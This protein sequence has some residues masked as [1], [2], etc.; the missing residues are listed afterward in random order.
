MK[1][2]AD[3]LLRYLVTD[4]VSGEDFMLLATNINCGD[5]VVLKFYKNKFVFE[6]TKVIHRKLRKTGYICKSIPFSLSIRSFLYRII[7]LIID[8]ELPPCLVFEKADISLGKWAETHSDIGTLKDAFLQVR[9][10]QIF[11]E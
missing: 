2:L 11:D 4:F 8:D 1:N 7:D 10:F 3:I 9:S 6:K 5:E